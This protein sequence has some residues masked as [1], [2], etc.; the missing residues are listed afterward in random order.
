MRPGGRIGPLLELALTRAAAGL[1]G[2]LAGIGLVHVAVAGNPWGIPVLAVG[3][4]LLLH[5]IRRAAQ[6]AAPDDRD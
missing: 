3:L 4:V 5:G 6:L 2:A 1:G